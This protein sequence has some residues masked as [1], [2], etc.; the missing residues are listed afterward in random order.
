[1][2]L[3][4]SKLTMVLAIICMMEK[5][6]ATDQ[7]RTKYL[8]QDKDIKPPNIECPDNVFSSTEPKKPT[9]RVKWRRPFATDN[10]GHMPTIT[11][12]PKGIV[13]PHD[14]PI[15]KTRIIY[16]ATDHSGNSHSCVFT[17]TIVDK[18]PP[19]ITCP[20][21]MEVIKTGPGHTTVVH[22]HPPT[23]DD[24]SGG[25]VVL[26]TESV[27]GS[28]FT[29]GRHRITYKAT[30]PSG[31]KASCTFTITV[32][33][34]KCPAYAPPLNG[35]MAC[36]HSHLLG[37]TVCT[38]QCNLPRDFTRVPAH[39]YICQSTGTWFAWDS[40]PVVSQELP[41]PDCTDVDG[42]VL[43]RKG[44][45]W[46]SF[47]GDC[48]DP[49]VQKLAKQN[50]VKAFIDVFGQDFGLMADDISIACGKSRRNEKS[51]L[52]GAEFKSE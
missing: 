14:F 39:M 12:F 42:P 31:N 35:L 26:F 41:W 13:S 28:G 29:V 19:K 49:K 2:M 23:A 18:E 40:R 44:M 10:S 1:M 46:Q 24:N 50:L 37:G 52:P 33:N 51:V 21:D 48:L 20:K 27:A 30:D 16:T 36:A 5:V 3:A 6:L 22:W 43:F 7:G 15:G 38:P 17:V 9:R 47:S 34:P 11:S 4:G 25:H 8:Q 45:S 32:S